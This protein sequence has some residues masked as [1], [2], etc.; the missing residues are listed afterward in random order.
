MASTRIPL[1]TESVS[2]K[3]GRALMAYDQLEAKLL[4]HKSADPVGDGLR[5]TR[6]GIE[7][8]VWRESLRACR[9]REC[10]GT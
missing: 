8:G 2:V 10:G 5:L 9:K 1:K 6:I 3:L 7:I 4:E